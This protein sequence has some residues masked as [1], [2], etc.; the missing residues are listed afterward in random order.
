MYKF[1]G[2]LKNFEKMKKMVFES[3]E[4]FLL[5]CVAAR[6]SI[7]RK[8]IFILLFKLLTMI[9]ELGNWQFVIFVFLLILPI[10][11]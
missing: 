3:K 2:V 5:E 10:S 4:F 8:M 11:L 9:K 6:V 7:G 1:F